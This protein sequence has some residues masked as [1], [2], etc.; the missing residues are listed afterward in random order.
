MIK[1]INKNTQAVIEVS[2]SHFIQ[3][4]SQQGWIELKLP[5]SV[6]EYIDAG[7][8]QPIPEPKKKP[9]KRKTKP[10]SIVSKL[11]KGK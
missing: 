5:T 10:R 4:L 2:P 8:F 11:R 6:Q 9:V 3:V 1:V 7:G